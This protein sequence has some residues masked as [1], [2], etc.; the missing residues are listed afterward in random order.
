MAI[1]AIAVPT[2]VGMANPN[3]A[4][5]EDANAS[6]AMGS[7]YARPIVTA[8]VNNAPPPAKPPAPAFNPAL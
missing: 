4:D 8:S 3:D 1:L 2:D 6:P 5:N 7:A